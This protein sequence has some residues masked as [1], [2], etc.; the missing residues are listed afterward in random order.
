MKLGSVIEKNE[1]RVAIT[2][3]TAKRY[4]N[5]GIQ[6]V[7]ETGYGA[8]L[9]S[10][11]EYETAGATFAPEQTV[12]SAATIVQIKSLPVEQMSQ[13]ASKTVFIALTNPFDSIPQP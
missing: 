5:L 11:A 9:Y 7:V 13:L 1:S 8:H 10:A 2:P 3:E 4:V 6:V 12:L